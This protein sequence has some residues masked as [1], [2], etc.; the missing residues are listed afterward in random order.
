MKV[1]LEI[2]TATID[3][4]MQ[5]NR[6]IVLVVFPDAERAAWY[7]EHCFEYY[8][9]VIIVSMDG[10]YPYHHA[11]KELVCSLW[12][13]ANANIIV[14][15]SW[16]IEETPPAGMVF[17]LDKWAVEFSRKR[18]S[19]VHRSIAS[20]DWTDDPLT[21]A[22]MVEV[23]AGSKNPRNARNVNMYN[24]KNENYDWNR[25]PKNLK[26]LLEKSKKS[27]DK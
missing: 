21:L 26:F 11:L 12:G 24:V 1:H 4:S 7:M 18:S 22:R 10:V 8:T 15:G 13:D 17:S 27:V 16:C 25:L 2:N 20:L 14:F 3:I 9:R 5:L 23:F 19:T 6:G